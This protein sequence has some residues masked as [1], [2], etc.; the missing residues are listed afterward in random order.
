M[1]AERHDVRLAAGAGE[2]MSS[3]AANAG[4]YLAGHQERKQVA[5]GVR[6]EAVLYLDQVVLMTPKSVAAEVIDR[7]VVEADDLFNSQLIEDRLEDGAAGLV[8]RDQV[9]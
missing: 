3:D 9:L 6:K 5:E 1:L 7:I 4:E 8:V 2:P